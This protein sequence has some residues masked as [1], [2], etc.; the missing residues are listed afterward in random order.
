MWHL[1]TGAKAYPVDPSIHIM[2]NQMEN[3]MDSDTETDVI[4]GCSRDPT[5]TS[6]LDR[7]A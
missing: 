2:E 4:K 5:F 6:Y 7:E 3:P 1:M